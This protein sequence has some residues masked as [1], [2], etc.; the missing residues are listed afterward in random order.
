MSKIHIA[1]VGGQS[2]PVYLGIVGTRPNRVVLITSEQTRKSVDTIKSVLPPPLPI[3]TIV[4]SPVDPIKIHQVASDLAEKYKNDEVYVNIS[5]GTKAW[6][7]IFGYIFQ[8]LENATVFYIDQNSVLWNY[9]TMQSQLVVDFDMD[10]L[11]RLQENALK[12]YVPFAEYTEED[13]TAMNQLVS[14]RKYNCGKFNK[15]TTLLTKDW[16]E[17]IQNQKC[18]CLSLSESDYVEWEKPDFVRLVL[19]TKKGGACEYTIE[20]PHAVSLAFRTHWFEFKIAKMLSL[21]KYAKDIRL[22]CVFPPKGVNTTKYPKNEVDII[23]NTG[24]KILF[25]E[26]KTQISNSTDIDKFRTVVKNYGGNGSKALFITDNVMTS[27]QKEK[28]K[29]SEIISFSL[30]D[31]SVGPNK[32]QELFK[33]L[34]QELFKINAK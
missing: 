28:C 33:L 11:F 2:I 3:E 1:L 7:H 30:Q 21:W 10:V 27:L 31:A 8:A 4:V 32:E 22:N 13:V 34:E 23:V 14:A 5:G 26:C 9:K 12:H 18:G 15:L 20:S 6:T 17:K 16:E 29:E 24:V 19:S 25:V